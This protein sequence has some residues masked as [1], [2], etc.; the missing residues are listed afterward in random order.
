MSAARSNV[1][2]HLRPGTSLCRPP[3]RFFAPPARLPLA[4]SE[5]PRD[6]QAN[7]PATPLEFLLECIGFGPNHDLGGL[8]SLLENRGLSVPGRSGEGDHRR[9]LLSHGLEV[10]LDPGQPARGEHPALAPMLW[11]GVAPGRPAALEVRGLEESHG[12]PFSSVVRASLQDSPAAR[13]E[14]T[15]A[16]GPRR[17]DGGRAV[18]WAFALVDD[19]PPPELNQRIEVA[20]N[21]FALDV[22]ALLPAPARSR[23]RLSSGRGWLTPHFGG[24]D[25]PG[26]VELALPIHAVQ[27]LYNPI[28]QEQVERVVCE[29]HGVRLELY[30][31]RWQR[32][33]DGLPRPEPGGWIAGTF[34]LMG[35]R[36]EGYP[37]PRRAVSRRSSV[38]L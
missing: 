7:F 36:P 9:L 8:Y 29:V 13:A 33:E 25:L 34:L 20:L 35:R 31:S 21:G 28:T 19:G 24:P 1:G 27:V 4:A 14:P 26:C 30:T 15:S 17:L 16:S 6:P 23:S 32:E 10:W 37:F 11:P 12:A 38:R 18:T 22:T 3:V 2:G 5:R